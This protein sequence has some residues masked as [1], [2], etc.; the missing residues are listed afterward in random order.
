MNG[1]CVNKSTFCDDIN[2]CGDWSDEPLVCDCPNYLKLSN[3]SKICDGE[4]NCYDKTDE[5][6]NIC[7][8]TENS[9]Y[10]EKYVKS[11][12]IC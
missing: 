6:P 7:N 8:C 12:V 2:D 1:K 9:Y 5:D 10:C 4:I 3:G 11:N